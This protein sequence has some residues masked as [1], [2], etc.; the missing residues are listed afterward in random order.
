MRMFDW[1]FGASTKRRV[2]S[3]QRYPYQDNAAITEHVTSLVRVATKS[4]EVRAKAPDP[5]TV[6][7]R[8]QAITHAPPQ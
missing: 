6:A 8:L 3:R 1:L 2:E 7:P 4:V 5:R